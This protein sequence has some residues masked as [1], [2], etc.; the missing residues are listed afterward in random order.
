MSTSRRAGT[1]LAVTGLLGATVIGGAPGAAA[2]AE[3][4]VYA[5]RSTGLTAD[6]ATA[7]QRAFG[8]KSVHRAEDGSVS[9][10]DE[11][12]Y[13]R[14]PGLDAGTGQADEEG[15]ATTGTKL[16]LDAIKRLRAIGEAD[17]IKKAAE[18][19][20][21]VGLLPAGA[22]PT[23]RQTTLEVV[24]ADGKAVVSAPLDTAVSFALSVDGVPLEGAGAKIRI[25]FDGSGAVSA[26]T[27]STRELVKVGSVP[28]LDQAGARE[29]CL[30]VLGADTR[31]SGV[32]Y[33]Y[34]SPALDE[35]VDRLEP[36]VR[37]LAEVADT[38]SAQAVT[39]PANPS[40]SLPQ[41]DPTPPPREASFGTASIPR[42]D[43]GDEGTGWCAGLP[44]TNLNN[45]RF[46]AE[47]T[48]RGIPVQFKWRDTNAWERDFK[49]PAFPYGWDQLYVDDVDLTYWTGRGSPTGLS[50]AGCSAQSDSFLANTEARWG[51]RDLEWLSLYAPGVLRSTWAGKSWAARWGK[52]FQGLH[53]INGFDSGVVHTSTHGRKFGNYLL[54]TPFLWWNKPLK[55]RAAWAQASIDT[56]P[57]SVVWST[58]GPIGSSW[59][60]NFDDYF[61]G[62]GPVGPDT[63]PT[64][65]WWRIS[66]TS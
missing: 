45:N 3:L 15:Q 49:D 47:F 14:V 58:M 43:V 9:F 56:Q 52:A 42:V 61:W 63:L 55:V 51:N 29:R 18:T 33:V 1:W 30:K 54:R 24:D 10:A 21:G 41:P 8:L 7:L 36:S 17:A 13:L 25:A 48:G 57:S 39:V 60:A 32:S 26:L 20:R 5:V 46:D 35:K 2:A 6:Q 31:L 53:Q 28:V 11:A 64:V 65:G 37:C 44:L 23:A 50:F 66:G 16:D 59:I 12:T 22:T 19:L 34:D 27:Y 40:A 4:P 62:K 38:P